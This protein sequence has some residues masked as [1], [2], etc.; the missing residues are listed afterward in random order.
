MMVR[1]LDPLQVPVKPQ[2]GVGT[3]RHH[4]SVSS[5]IK[6][7]DITNQSLAELLSRFLFGVSVLLPLEIGSGGYMPASTCSKMQNTE[8]IGTL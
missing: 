6:F 2:L 8:T 4:R 7:V 3:P 5:A 1:D